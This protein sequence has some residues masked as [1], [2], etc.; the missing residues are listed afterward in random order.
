MNA[1]RRER[2]AY[3]VLWT[4]FEI[5]GVDAPGSGS[6]EARLEGTAL[7]KHALIASMSHLGPL[8]IGFGIHSDHQNLVV[9]FSNRSKSAAQIRRA[10]RLPLLGTGAQAGHAFLIQ[11]QGD[12]I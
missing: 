4:L 3:G 10:Y 6:F 1:L 7:E 5:E 12:Q 9:L 2:P 11:L 8:T